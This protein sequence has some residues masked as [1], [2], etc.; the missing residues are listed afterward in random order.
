MQSSAMNALK[1]RFSASI[2]SVR[3]SRFGEWG[4][5]PDPARGSV[6]VDNPETADA[7]LRRSFASA[8][9]QEA[10]R[11]ADS[12]GEEEADAERA[13][14]HDRQLRTQGTRDVHALTQALRGGGELL[15]LLLEIAP[16]VRDAAGLATSRCHRSSVLRSSALP[17]GSPA[18]A[19]AGF[20][21]G[22]S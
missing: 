18:R 10:S 13:R 6:V 14:R 9:H 8:P 7:R 4:G 20:L 19:P 16:D 11:R 2:Q 12:A 1:L 3:E 21:F 17:R 22:C 15:A 5:R